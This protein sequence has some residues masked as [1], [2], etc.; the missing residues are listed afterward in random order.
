MNIFQVKINNVQNIRHLEF[1]I[2]LNFGKLLCIVGKNGVGKT[3]FIKSIANLLRADIFK[4]TSSPYIFNNNSNITYGIDDKNYIYTYN[5]QLQTIDSKDVIE[6]T[7][8]NN[9]IGELPLPY[10]ERFNFFQ[11]ISNL[12]KEIR[13]KYITKDYKTPKELINWYKNIYNSDKF[14]VLKEVTINNKKYY[15]LPQENNKYIREDYFSSGEYFVL[16]IYRL[17]QQQKKLVII[18]ELDISLDASAQVHLLKELREFCKSK[19][20]TLIFTTHS[21]AIM[22]MLK[23]N[24]LHYLENT[25]GQCKITKKSYNYIKGTLYQFKG[26]DKYILTE[27]IVLQNFMLW[28]LVDCQLKKKYIIIPIGVANSVVALM[29]NNNGEEFFSTKNNVITVLDGDQEKNYNTKPNV[30][31]LPFKSVEKKLKELYDI[32]KTNS[33]IFF[34]DVTT[35]EPDKKGRD[36]FRRMLVK[37][38]QNE[39]FQ[40]IVESNNPNVEKFKQALQSFINQ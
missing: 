24:E 14:N 22:K 4:T 33:N 5:K 40:F 1:K 20:V 3:T 30:L 9:I 35:S 16:S 36:I 8:T 39:I 15:F 19:A 10:G 7:I 31:F 11:I 34:N 18:D 17:I 26:W 25:N 6:N 13:Q 37:K 29:N 2:D 38:T 23:D 28:L 27:D 32:N 12:D 21:L